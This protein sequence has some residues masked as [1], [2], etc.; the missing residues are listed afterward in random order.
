VDFRVLGPV[1]VWHNGRQVQ[2]DR[3]QQ[4]VVLGILALEANRPVSATG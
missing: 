2:F 1:E 3:R 4:R